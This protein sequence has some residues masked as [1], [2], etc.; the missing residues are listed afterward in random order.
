M[1]GTWNAKLSIHVDVAV[2]E[3]LLLHEIYVV[4]LM[5]MSRMQEHL[6]GVVFPGRPLLVHVRPKNSALLAAGGGQPGLEVL[7]YLVVSV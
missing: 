6:L 2:D 1:R 4:M 7:V 5:K 3:L